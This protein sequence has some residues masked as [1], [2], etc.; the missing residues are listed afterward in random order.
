M[1]DADIRTHLAGIPAGRRL[2]TELEQLRRRDA[3][4][5]AGA[6][7]LV[8]RIEVLM[9]TIEVLELAQQRPPVQVSSSDP[10]SRTA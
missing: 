9:R 4:N 2:L 6:K 3:D 5:A 8:E 10:C 7:L 1:T